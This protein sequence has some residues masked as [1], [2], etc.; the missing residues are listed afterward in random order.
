MGGEGE[1][2]EEEGHE[3]CSLSSS[4]PGEARLSGCCSAF[5]LSPA[6]R[7]G[8]GGHLHTASVA[9]SPCCVTLFSKMP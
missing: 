5:G 9:S 1:E 3:T 8:T 7:A 2:R 6:R 4:L